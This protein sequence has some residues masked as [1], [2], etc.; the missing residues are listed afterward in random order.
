[1]SIKS[2]NLYTFI[3][4]LITVVNCLAQSKQVAITIYN[5]D[6]ALVKDT[7]NL[8]LKKGISEIKFTDVAAK[9]DPTSVYF[10]SKTAPD[11][12]QILEQNYEYD[13]VNSA[14]IL[15]KYLDQEINLEAKENKTYSGV[16]LN[17]SGSEVILRESDGGIKIVNMSSVENMSFPKLPEGLITRPTLVWSINC[18]RAGEHKTEVG[19]L[20]SGIQWHAEYVGISNKDDSILELGAWVSIDNKSQSQ[21]SFQ[22]KI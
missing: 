9:I 10:V 1:M 8:N 19:Y 12:V 16:L 18:Q 11:K 20:T 13:L 6:L 7:R 3:I 17:S 2:I 15:Q 21:Y 14:K 5:D 22:K 4:V